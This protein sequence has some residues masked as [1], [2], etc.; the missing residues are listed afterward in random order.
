MPESRPVETRPGWGVQP[1]SSPAD[2]LTRDLQAACL[3][4]FGPD[5]GRAVYPKKYFRDDIYTYKGDPDSPTKTPRAPRVCATDDGAAQVAMVLGATRGVRGN[6]MYY[7]T[8]PDPFD[9]NFDPAALN[10]G[11]R[12][13][14]TVPYLIFTRGG[15]EGTPINAAYL[16]DYFNHGYS[17]AYA[18]ASAQ[19]EIDGSFGGAQ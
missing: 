11:W 5:P 1:P 7:R 12:D 9:P 13:S 6:A 15:V 4:Q 10:D 14:D 8:P 3:E 16:L 19:A 2:A 18:V 17:V